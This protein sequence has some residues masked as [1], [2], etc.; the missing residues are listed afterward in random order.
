[1]TKVLRFF[2]DN[3][4]YVIAVIIAASISIW[5]YGCDS[6]VPSMMDPAKKINRAELELESDYLIGQVKMKLADLDKQD[7]IKILML[8]Q[9]LIFGESGT[10]NPAGLLNTLISI[11][12][13]S[14]GLNR[15]QKLRTITKNTTQT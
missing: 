6:Q 15:N 4:W 5:L 1:M 12:A 3:H 9:A 13:I 11:G 14:F 10:F 2:N 7:E 8:E